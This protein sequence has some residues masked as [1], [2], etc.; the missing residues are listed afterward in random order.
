[1]ELKIC[2]YYSLI[3]PITIYASETW[4]L[5]VE[6]ERKLLSFEMKCLRSLLGVSLRD[7]LKNETIRK[8]LNVGMSITDIIRK[9]RMKWFGHVVHL[10]QNSYVSIAYK[11][12]F[13]IKRPK[14][15]PP[16]RWSDQLRNDTGLPLLTA[17]RIRKDREKWRSIKKNVA[18]LS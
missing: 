13:L 18:R 7:R 10:P 2:L 16:E 12:D 15:R 17:E 5:R 9:K 6:G 1:M 8:I 14:G 3:V 11:Q 4:S